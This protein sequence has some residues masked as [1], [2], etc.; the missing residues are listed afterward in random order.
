MIRQFSNSYFKNFKPTKTGNFF[1]IINVT[2][3]ETNTFDNSYIQLLELLKAL[4]IEH[5]LP[6]KISWGYERV[7]YESFCYSDQF[8]ASMQS[9]DFDIYG[10]V[11]EDYYYD[12][13]DVVINNFLNI[14]FTNSKN[15]V[16]EICFAFF[17][18]TVS[19]LNKVIDKGYYDFSVPENYNAMFEKAINP[20]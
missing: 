10:H 2:R 14:S 16:F 15:E 8:D 19:I 17:G 3:N 13:K 5:S 12:R 6:E 20:S 1:N 11:E 18:A 9:N 4:H 7:G